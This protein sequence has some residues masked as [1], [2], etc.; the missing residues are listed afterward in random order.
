MYSIRSRQS[1]QVRAGY[2]T[3]S[4]LCENFVED[5]QP[6]YLL[7]FLLTGSYAEA[8]QCFVATVDDAITANGVFKGWE[9]SWNKRCL[10]INAIHRVFLAST[11]S[12]GKRDAGRELGVESRVHPVIDAVARLAPP[13]QR[14]V[15]V[16]SVLEG[17]SEHECALLLGRTPRDVREARTYA[18]WQFA[19]ITP[20]MAKIR[21]QPPIYGS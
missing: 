10:I 20:A 12:G 19:G 9:R 7:A 8:E 11:P 15:F 1:A 13:L 16:I 17:Y 4:D 2:A 18:L 5:L 3:S 6:L 14:F 21:R